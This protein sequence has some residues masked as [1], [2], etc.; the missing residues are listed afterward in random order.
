LTAVKLVGSRATEEYIVT[1][2]LFGF[3]RPGD[4][5]VDIVVV[6]VSTTDEVFPIL[7]SI[8]FGIRGVLVVAFV[9]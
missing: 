4:V 8:G 5:H 1:P 3:S 2:D 7:V 6:P 9:Q